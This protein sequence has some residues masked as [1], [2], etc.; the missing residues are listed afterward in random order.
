MLKEHELI[1]A[2]RKETSILPFSAGAHRSFLWLE[3]NAL[4]GAGMVSCPQA[5]CIQSGKDPVRQ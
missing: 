2:K 3:P 4:C 1:T 5:L